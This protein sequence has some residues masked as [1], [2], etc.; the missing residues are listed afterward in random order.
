MKY[1]IR[2]SI[3]RLFSL[4]SSFLILLFFILPP[5]SI[6]AQTFNLKDYVL[7]NSYAP[8]HPTYTFKASKYCPYD[9]TIRPIR[10]DYLGGELELHSAPGTKPQCKSIYKITWAF[11]KDMRTVTCGEKVFID[12]TNRPIS[13]GECGIFVWEGD[14][15]PSSITLLAGSGVGES[16]LVYE[17]RK[18]DP[19]SS[20]RDY[21]FQHY[22]A[23]AVQGEPHSNNY[24]DDYHFQG[25]WELVVCPR[26]DFAEVA[27][28]GSFV[29]RIG[30]RGISFDVVYL[31]TKDA[32]QVKSPVTS[33]LELP[34][35]QHNIP[36][37]QGTYWMSI[38]VP[39]TLQGFN[40]KQAMMVL[41]FVD[42]NGNFLPGNAIDAR[43]VDANG[44][45]ATGS[46][47]INVNANQFN[48][49]SL[50]LWMPY[51][52]LNLPYS[53]G[54][55]PNDLSAFAEVIIDGKVVAQSQRVPLRVVW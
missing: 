31:Y 25:R 46:G 49:S 3:L 7:G 19:G 39:G 16:G 14:N 40:G 28:G 36:N 45:A 53:G 21:V 55:Q 18:S 15:N 9:W 37:D 33:S 34:I 35:F 12:I 17:E 8:N 22:P 52:A 48:L 20:Y 26:P 51:Y 38:Q 44:Y 32:F 10:V 27:N 54:Q 23:K 30:N 2:D 24:A 29:F 5:T 1:P 41:R 13:K 47:W 50:T 4:I 43:Y 42:A 11:S 6:P